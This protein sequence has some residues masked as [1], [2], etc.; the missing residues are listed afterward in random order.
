ML[1]FTNFL[2]ILYLCFLIKKREAKKPPFFRLE[3]KVIF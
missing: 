3:E 2:K 1:K